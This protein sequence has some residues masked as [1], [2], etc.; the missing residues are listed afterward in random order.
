M[1][2]QLMLLPNYKINKNYNRYLPL[3]IIVA[4]V[5]LA[6]AP[7][8]Q[9]KIPI[10]ARNLVSF[11]SPWYYEKF[12][13]F[14]AGVPGKPGMLD[15]L[16]LYYPY[17]RLT[18]E[19]Y[20]HGELPLWNPYNFAGNPHMAEW[21]SG[22]FYPLHILLPLLPLQVYWTLFQL[23]AFFL[24]GLFT[25]WYLLNLKIGKLA[26]IFGGTTFMFSEFMV[27]W[28]MEVVTAPHSI[29]WLP[30]ILLAVDRFVARPKAK[31]RRTK[32]WWLVGLGGLVM[33]I[34][35]GY[36]QTT[37]YVMAVTLIYTVYR[38]C[39]WFFGRDRFFSWKKIAVTPEPR[40][41]A[42][43]TH[44]RRPWEQGSVLWGLFIF[45]WIPLSLGLT[46]FH[47][48]PTNELLGRSSREYIN[49]QSRIQ[50]I[51][52]GYLLPARHLVTLFSPDYFGHEATRNYFARVG[53]GW[54][55]EHVI[56]VGTIPL[57][58]SIV[59]LAAK[60]KG[61][62]R[63]DIL[64]WLAVIVIS[65]S[66]S[67]KTP[68][69]EA[70]FSY[71]IPVLST[72]IANRI[73]FVEAF[74]LSV[75]S[76]FG[77]SL[78]ADSDNRK[79]AIKIG[80]AGALGIIVLFFNTLITKTSLGAADPAKDPQLYLISLRNMVLP[81]AVYFLSL[82][83]LG[84]AI[85]KNGLIK[86]SIAGIILISL[87]Q[88]IYQFRKFTAF[89]EKMFIYPVHPTINWLQKNSGINRFIGYNGKF[90]GDNFATN[91]GIYSIEGYDSLN[92]YKRS[93]LLHSAVEGKLDLDLPRSADV[94]LGR[95]LEN[96]RTI[97]LMKLFGIKY[98]VDHPEWLDT[99]PTVNK[100]R[101][102]DDSQRLVFKNGDWK[103]WDFLD[104]FPRAFLAGKYEVIPDGEKLISRLYEDSFDPRQSILLD[105]EP[106]KD[107]SI[108]TDE[109]AQVK[110]LQYR[111]TKI[112]FET[113]S[114]SDQLL[115][116]SDTWYPGWKAKLEN[117]RELKIL[118]ADYALRAVP[119]PAGDHTI[120]MWY[121]PA[122][123][124]IGLTVAL[125][126]LAAV[127]FMVLI[128]IDDK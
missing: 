61:K 7:I 15:Q 89:S 98:L 10:N 49:S 121:F 105:Q 41:H 5:V 86:I 107:F 1:V 113:S 80:L 65:A 75:L 24:S 51:L 58:L 55:Y 54:Y 29:L 22:V 62:I 47:L 111:P 30:L 17:M 46:S 52:K 118:T 71:N 83:L 70:V 36:W 43:A 19:A 18:Q 117:G 38:L 85:R 16:R 82:I 20:R 108:S 73:L 13:G 120:T 4:A 112:V 84:I 8:F 42:L 79:R 81:S 93:V 100:K 87:A 92:D 12:A 40:S 2:K 63:K 23:M 45:L 35:A 122:A 127:G 116:L 104:A 32:V 3:L 39:Y 6:F 67:F 128:K 91:F 97:K 123:F 59:A 48:L 14:P 25:Y 72:G 44:G 53:G 56:F 109:L 37:L 28:N 9:G 78:L 34:L 66:F 74:G 31:G 68:W 69:A 102:P 88:N 95:N 103:I 115:F 124:K 94:V 60:K 50:E 76:A 125:A 114:A 101:L 64:F 99:G 90:L 110:I 106:G 21:Q 33:S 96:L 57:L 126:T 26:A 77:I 119:V 11:F 27:T